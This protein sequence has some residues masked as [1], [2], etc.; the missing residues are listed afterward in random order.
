MPT[1][2]SNWAADLLIQYVTTEIQTLEPELQFA[3]LG[4]QKDIPQGWNE[5]TFPQTNQIASSSV[6]SIS[7]GVNPSEV[8]WG[9]TAYTVGV[10]QHGLVVEV[11]DLLVRNSAIEVIQSATRQVKLAL[12]RDID[13]H[14]QTVVNAGTNVLYAGGKSSRATLAAGDTIDTTL[15]VKAIKTLRAANVMPFNGSSYAVVMHPNQ[16]TDL[17]LNTAPGAWIDMGRYTS[18]SELLDGKMGHFRGGMIYGSANVQTFSST[19]TVYPATFIGK[20]SFGW[21]YFQ[22]PQ[23]ILTMNPDSNNPL[24]VFQTI[25]AKA[26]LGVTRFEEARLAR[27]ET[28]VSA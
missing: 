25:G 16:E 22:T 24:N 3:R 21:G 12:A 11:S 8:T 4:V 5:L 28:A 19:V 10:T 6:S 9:S 26:A 14:I 18:V 27:V 1:I 7:E 20:E 13:D 15:Y 2:R 17:M 23:P